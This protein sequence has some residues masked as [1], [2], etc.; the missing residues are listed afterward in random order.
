MLKREWISTCEQS[1]GL[2]VGEGGRTTVDGVRYLGPAVT[3]IGNK[4]EAVP[5]FD[6]SRLRRAIQLF[7]AS[8]H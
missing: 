2:L 3:S 7:N 6:A 1:G 8:L 5:L 4:V